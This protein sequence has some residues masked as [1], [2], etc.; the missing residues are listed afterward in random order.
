MKYESSFQIHKLSISDV[1]IAYRIP[2]STVLKHIKNGELSVNKD[3]L[4]DYYQL[5]DFM[6]Q[7]NGN[8]LTDR[9]N[10]LLT[11]NAALKQKIY[12][13]ENMLQFKKEI[14]EKFIIDI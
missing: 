8:V 4:I 5:I 12:M 14:F 13:L 11:E 6:G 10:Q 3:K 1:A 2:R 7:P 9:T